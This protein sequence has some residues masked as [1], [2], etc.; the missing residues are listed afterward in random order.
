M[1]RQNY[2]IFRKGELRNRLLEYFYFLE[3][4][5]TGNEV[6]NYLDNEFT[7]KELED[8]LNEMEKEMTVTLAQKKRV[9]EILSVLSL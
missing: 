7:I 9:G 1:Y 3:R 2:Q 6:S 8:M 4:E 5:I